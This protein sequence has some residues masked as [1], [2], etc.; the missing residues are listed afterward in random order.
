MAFLFVNITGL[1]I[2]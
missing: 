2:Y 1:D